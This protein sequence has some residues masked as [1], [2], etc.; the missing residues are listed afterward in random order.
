MWWY[1]V[2]R[3][4]SI[5]VPL[6]SYVAKAYLLPAHFITQMRY[7]QC[8]RKRPWLTH[9][10]LMLSYLT[11]LVLIMF[12]LSKMASGPKIDWS[13]HIF[14]YLGHR[15]ARRGQR[16]LPAQSTAEVVGAVRALTRIRLDVPRAA[17]G[18]G[19]DRHHPE[20]PAP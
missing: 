14:G 13:V 20:H 10:V 16:P 12:F 11:M 8:E 9:L 19:S 1:T 2:G 18:R 6:K 5:K 4:R 17:S 15:R 7:A 3:D